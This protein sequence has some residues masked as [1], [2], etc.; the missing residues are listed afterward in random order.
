MPKRSRE[1][2]S[3]RFLPSTNHFLTLSTERRNDSGVRHQQ[4]PL[5][6]LAPSGAPLDNPSLATPTGGKVGEADTLSGYTQWG[7]ERAGIGERRE[8]YGEMEGREGG[9]LVG[10]EVNNPGRFMAP[11]CTSHANT[12]L[13]RHANTTPLDN[14]LS[15]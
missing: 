6:P 9:S 7:G 15:P 8:T 12:G 4:L 2:P 1:C 11:A 13:Q 3:T 10:A 5:P 14:L